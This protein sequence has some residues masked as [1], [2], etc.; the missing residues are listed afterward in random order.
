MVFENIKKQFDKKMKFLRKPPEIGIFGNF[1]M[2]RCY[3]K[4]FYTTE[5]NE[6]LHDYSGHY[7]HENYNDKHMG[8][9]EF[10]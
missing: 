4:K 2:F 8:R 7:G 6:I 9:R 10:F 1:H 3:K 5:F